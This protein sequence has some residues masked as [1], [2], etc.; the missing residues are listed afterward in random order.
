MNGTSRAAGRNLRLQEMAP[1]TL[2]RSGANGVPAEGC[3][4]TGIFANRCLANDVDAP[5]LGPY[6]GERPVELSYLRLLS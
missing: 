5:A 6:A 2:N 1:P 3:P 4:S